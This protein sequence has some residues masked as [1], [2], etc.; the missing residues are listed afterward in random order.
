MRTSL[1]RPAVVTVRLSEHERAALERLAL[2]SDR[3]VADQL[4]FLLHRAI[5]V[6]QT[7]LELIPES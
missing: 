1:S 7:P 5:D 6:P 3:T 4:R 2:D